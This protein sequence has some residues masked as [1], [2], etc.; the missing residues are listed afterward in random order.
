ML[1]PKKNEKFRIRHTK[2]LDQIIKIKFRLKYYIL[3]IKGNY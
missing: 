2:I 3:L 1:S